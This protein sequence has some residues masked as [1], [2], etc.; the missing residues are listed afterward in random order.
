MGPWL[1]MGAVLFAGLAAAAY[2]VPIP[3][4]TE[5]TST[6]PT[7]AHEPNAPTAPDPLAKRESSVTQM[8]ADLAARE[9]ALKEQ[10]A[11]VASLL[12]DLTA[13]NSEGSSLRKA[14]EMYAAMPPYKAAPLLQALDTESAVQILRF[15]DREDAAAILGHMEI[16]TST[17][18]MRE[19]IKPQTAPAQPVAQPPSAGTSAPPNG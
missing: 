4:L 2:Y 17:Q 1:L 8:E 14:A 5:A 7:V 19:L 12:M 16:D 11:R 10:E 13:Q 9:A 6:P 15:L 18:L 3:G